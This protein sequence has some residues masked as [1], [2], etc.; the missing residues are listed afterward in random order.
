MNESRRPFVGLLAIYLSGCTAF[1]LEHRVLY[2]SPL[3][4]SLLRDLLLG[5]YALAILRTA[6]DWKHNRL[7]LGAAYACAIAS[8]PQEV[9]DSTVFRLFVI[10]WV[11]LGS[12]T[13]F[14]D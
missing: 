3:L 4:T 9:Q 11:C 1:D 13:T 8:V 10:V 2:N 5:I 14:Q 7:G 12:V 6:S